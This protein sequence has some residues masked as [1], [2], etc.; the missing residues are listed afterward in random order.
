M[1]TNKR[2]EAQSSNAPV[3]LR[4]PLE[5]WIEQLL[6]KYPEELAPIQPERERR[7]SQRFNRMRRS[8]R[9]HASRQLF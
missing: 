7:R 3:R 1:N 8:L 6:Q 2:Y 5:D 9:D 4:Y